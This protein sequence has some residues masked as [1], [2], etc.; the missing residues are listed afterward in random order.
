MIFLLPV[1]AAIAPFIL[2]PI[3]TI[4]PYP[5]LIEEAVKGLM[6]Y[7][8]L[9]LP[10]NIQR[11]ALLVSAVFFTLSESVLYLF[12][13]VAVGNIFTFLLRLVLTGSLHTLTVAIMFAFARKNQKWIVVGWLI[14][15]ILHSLFNKTIA[16]L[17]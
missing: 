3:E 7:V 6:V 2:F 17:L 10:T 15:S 13:I 5:A 1:F 4:L 9:K 11:S 8:A 16:F 14:A 12:N